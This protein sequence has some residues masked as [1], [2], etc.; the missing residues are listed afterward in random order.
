MC[1]CVCVCV[2]ARARGLFLPT[3][4]KHHFFFTHTHT[5]T[6]TQGVAYLLRLLGQRGDFDSLHWFESVNERL[7]QEGTA[8]EAQR[9][10]RRKQSSDDDVQARL[11]LVYRWPECCVCHMC[12]FFCL[13]VPYCAEHSRDDHL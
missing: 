9:G 12:L 13:R 2:R 10:Q 1:V 5:H 7:R 6:W 3:G 11:L 4:T 8:L